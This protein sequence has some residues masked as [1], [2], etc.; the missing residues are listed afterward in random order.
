MPF[1]RPLAFALAAACL[2]A[3]AAPAAAIVGGTAPTRAYP[4]MGALQLKGD[5]I[6]GSSLVRADWILTAAHCVEGETATDYSVQLGT[7]KRSEGG[8]FVD[9]VEARIHPN[10]DGNGNDVALMRLARSVSHAPIRLADGMR[11]AA[12]YGAGAQ[13]TAIGW[14]ATI[15]TVGP[16]TD[17]LREITVPVRNDTECE[18]GAAGAGDYDPESMV[19]A[20]ETQGGEDTCQGDSGG[21][22]MATDAAGALV[23]TGATSFGLGCAFPGAYGVY[24]RIAGLRGFIDANLPPVPPAPGQPAPAPT[25]RPASGTPTSTAPAASPANGRPRLFL[26]AKLGSARKVKR[27]GAVSFALRSSGPVSNVKVTLKRGTRLLGTRTIRRLV[28]QA[29]VKI[30]VIR[31]RVKAGRLVLRVTARDGQNRV[32]TAS[33]RPTLAR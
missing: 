9:V 4:H 32:V 16:T 6:C 14:G 8:E 5:F 21:P 29:G 19:C 3:S 23:L 28:G 11:D 10:Y 24:A 22:L 18:I 25:P 30:K 2:M 20:G 7:A 27:T 31:S 12:F 15:S 33:G 26:P 17:D 13:V 1:P